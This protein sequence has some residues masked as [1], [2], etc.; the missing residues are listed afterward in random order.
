M[1]GSTFFPVVL[2]AAI[3]ATPFPAYAGADCECVGNGKRVKEG[4]VL[5]LQIGPSTR[6][7]A[8]CEKVLNNTSWKKLAEDCPQVQLDTRWC[9]RQIM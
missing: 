4:Q 7:L 8:R 6:Y 2:L 9:T 1:K 3:L 5:C